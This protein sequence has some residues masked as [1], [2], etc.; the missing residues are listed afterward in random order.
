VLEIITEV[1]THPSK[2]HFHG[3]PAEK[4]YTALEQ[5]TSSPSLSVTRS[6]SQQ[7]NKEGFGKDQFLVM[8]P[9]QV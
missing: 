4:R 6:D 5:K 9:R 3:S 2:L 8:V 1:F 7:L